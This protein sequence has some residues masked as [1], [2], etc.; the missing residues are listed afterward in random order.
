MDRVTFQ[1]IL[2]L[3]VKTPYGKQNQNPR[4]GKSSG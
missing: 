3:T 2:G 4:N 1:G